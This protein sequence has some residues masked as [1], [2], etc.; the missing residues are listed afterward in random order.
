[1]RGHADAQVMVDL[2]QRGIAGRGRLP[3]K[4]GGAPTAYAVV[5]VPVPDRPKELAR[6]FRDASA[7]GINIEDVSID[8]A[9][10]MPF[11]LVELSVRPES[12]SDLAAALR[13]A[14]WS[15]QA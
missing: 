8:H 5:S 14:G 11:G 10:G 2:L 1:L 3:G 13:S 15:I 6:L 12:S 9:P 7:V 4:H